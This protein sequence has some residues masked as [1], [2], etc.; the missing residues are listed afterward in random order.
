[1]DD[2]GNRTGNQTLRQH[3]TVH[4]APAPIASE[5]TLYYYNDQWQVVSTYDR[6]D[7]LG[8]C[9]RG[10]IFGNYIDEVLLMNDGTD[11]YFYLHDHLYSPV[12]LLDDTGDV[13]ERYEYDA[14]GSCRILDS[15]F[16]IRIS[17]LYGNPY[18][19]TGRELDIFD[20]GALHHMHFRHRDYSPTLARFFQQDPH[21]INPAG[22]KNN[23]FHFENLY[24]DG[25]NLYFYVKG[26]PTNFKDSMG[27]K[28]ES[29]KQCKII[30]QKISLN[31]NGAFLTGALNVEAVS[32]RPVR[33]DHL[34]S[35]ISNN[36]LYE[37]HELEFDYSKERQK[38]IGEGGIP[39]G[40]YRVNIC[41][42]SSMFGWGFRLQSFRHWYATPAWGFFSVPLH[43]EDGTETYGRGGFFIHGGNS[44]G[45]AGCIDIKNADYKLDRLFEKAYRENCDCCYIPVTVAYRWKRVIKHETQ[46][47]YIGMRTP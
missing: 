11:D 41:E 39:E 36:L 5:I 24:A 28:G 25:L 16:D 22:G 40:R 26:K 35:S 42:E 32:G 33:K 10:F 38:I 6:P 18:A 1:M 29:L 14:Y 37:R 7:A 46:I 15:N 44:W 2:L 31:F 4:F 13:L 3:G 8:V 20:G 30:G 43:P 17:S 45:S 9:T 12:A 23:A 19:F 34:G 27:L 47:Y 21:G